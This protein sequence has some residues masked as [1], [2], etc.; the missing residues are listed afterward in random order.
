MQR[1]GIP[2]VMHRVSSAAE[3]SL[4][5]Q[6]RA[7]RIDVEREYRFHETRRWRFDFAIPA[8]KIAIEIEG[9]IWTQGRHTRGKGYE[10]DL[11]KYEAALLAGWA[12]YRC[13]PAMVKSGAA[14]DTI[15]KLLELRG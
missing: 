12:V 14:V 6:C 2:N 15:T 5:L 13:S 11:E 10:Q 3:E 9:A 4:A 8:K 1:D 7:M